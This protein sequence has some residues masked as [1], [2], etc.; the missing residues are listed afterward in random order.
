MPNICGIKYNRTQTF[1]SYCPDV[2]VVVSYKEALSPSW[3]SGFAIVICGLKYV[4]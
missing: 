4:G 1:R 2:Q 3:D